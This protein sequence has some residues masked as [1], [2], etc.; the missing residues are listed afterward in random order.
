VQLR[1]VNAFPNARSIS[2]GSTSLIRRDITIRLPI[3]WFLSLLETFILPGVQ[4]TEDPKAR[5]YTLVHRGNA[6][7]VAFYT[8]LAHQRR[9]ILE[10]G[11][12]AGRITAATAAVAQQVVGIE[13]WEG[14]LA[15]AEPM[16]DN[17]DLL[18]GDACNF[19]LDTRFDTVVVPYNALFAFGGRDKII[20]AL[21]CARAH[22]DDGAKLVFDCYVLNDDDDALLLP[23]QEELIASII[24]NGRRINV[25]EWESPLPGP[26]AFQMQ[27]RYEISTTDGKQY[28]VQDTIAHHWL[29]PDEM[30]SVL[31][32]AGWRLDRIEAA[33]EDRSL[34]EDDVQM[35]IRGT[36][37][38]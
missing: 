21:R 19:A 24:D 1:V 5:L 22:A 27:Y 18:L 38:G 28:S 13:H 3:G 4:W 2:R 15:E 9:A 25:Y 17:A 37:V 8:R 14:M 30:D 12:G 10:L 33:F 6:G 16:P 35:V 26:R 36:A 32:A 29:P 31:S 23:V 34:Q 11:A 20:A 7:D